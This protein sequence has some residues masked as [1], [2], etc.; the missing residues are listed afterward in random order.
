LYK[1]RTH[2][3]ALSK[4]KEL[5][6]F[7]MEKPE[8]NAQRI[9][10]ALARRDLL[11]ELA[12]C[13]GDEQVNQLVTWALETPG[14][15]EETLAWATARAGNLKGGQTRGIKLTSKKHGDSRNLGVSQ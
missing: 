6:N 14:Q 8:G 2:A 15:S 12:D 3:L 10:E 1:V 11:L 9:Q 4:S 13:L 7:I 5:A